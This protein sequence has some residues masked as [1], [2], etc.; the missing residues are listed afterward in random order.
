MLRV[1]FFVWSCF[2]LSTC[3]EDE[4][5][6]DLGM[7]FAGPSAVEVSEDGKHFYVLNSDFERKYNE[8]S[9]LVI[10]EE[11]VK[12]TWIDVRRMGINMSV[13]GSRLLVIYDD[14]DGYDDE[15]EDDDKPREAAVEIF[16]IDE[17]DSSKLE[18]KAALSI[19]CSPINVTHRKDYK[20]FFVTCA[21]GDLFLG[22]F[23]DNLEDSTI[24][25]VRKYDY[26]R[27]ALYIDTK[28]DLLFA[29]ITDLAKQTTSDLK[30]LD[31]RAFSDDLTATAGPNEIPD[32]YEDTRSARTRTINRYRLQYVVY[33][34]KSESEQEPEAFPYRSLKD[35]EDPVAD[36]ELRWLYYTLNDF[37]GTPDSDDGVLD[38]NYKNY[39][40]NIWEAKPNPQD[41]DSFYI[42]HRGAEGSEN[43]NNIVKVSIIGDLKAT[44]ASSETDDCGP[45]KDN[46]SSMCVPKTGNVLSF[47]RVYGFNG[48]VDEFHYPGDFE[49]KEVNGQQLLL[50]NHFRD[51]AHWDSDDQRFSIEAKVIGQT[52]LSYLRD[53][54]HNRS[55]HEIAVNQR[56]RAL[57]SSF[58]GESVI[59]LNV[60]PG[61]SLEEVK[62]I[63]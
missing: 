48:E 31:S 23:G 44:P 5:F 39:R 4:V 22:Q 43:A 34:I 33:D 25:L 28:R 53:D 19:D 57:T 15:D 63:Y 58:Y 1:S 3:T 60:A 10:D 8:G 2:V 46:V 29:F 41:Q 62:Q 56:G 50:V 36:S 11:G 27:R 20:Y 16:S 51:L 9:L 42:S 6:P 55:Y 49:I 13:A 21:G 37:D 17:T 32:D 35:D 61:V 7:G 26:T 24:K 47:E 14:E 54:S 12:K 18:R 52:W 30:L 40:T 38:A 59:L 45:Q